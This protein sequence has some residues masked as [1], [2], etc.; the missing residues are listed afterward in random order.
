MNTENLLKEI[1]DEKE[2]ISSKVELKETNLLASHYEKD[3]VLLLPL[4]LLSVVLIIFGPKNNVLSLCNVIAYVCA[5]L[6]FLPFILSSFK[7]NLS[8]SYYLKYF[9]NKEKMNTDLNYEKDKVAS[10]KQLNNDFLKKIAIH[11]K[12][13]EFELLLKEC[14]GEINLEKIKNFVNKQKIAENKEKN[15]K[16]LTKAIYEENNLSLNREN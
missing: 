5:F 7:K 10:N 8:Y 11:M 13:N 9:F 3:V 1:N 2:K 14:E 4:M 12:E 6:P 16:S 15:I